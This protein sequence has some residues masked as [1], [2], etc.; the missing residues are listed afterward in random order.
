[1]VN[2]FLPLYLKDIGASGFYIALT[3]SGCALAK[4]L[5]TPLFGRWS[6]N[7]SRRLFISLGLS[8]YCSISFGCL[9]LPRSLPVWSL[10][11]IF[12]GVGAS[13]VRPLALASI[14]DI[15]PRNQEGMAMGTFD[16]S[17]YLATG[18]GP[19]LGGSMKDA[20][21][22][23]GIFGSLFGLC[24][25]ALLLSLFAVS[26]FPSAGKN[27]ETTVGFRVLSQSQGLLGLSCFIFTRSFGIVLVA[28]FL[29]VLLSHE[30]KL[31]GLQIG[32]VMAFGT[33]VTALFLRPFGEISDRVDRRV[34]IQIG[35]MSAALVTFLLPFAQGFWHMILFCGGIGFFSALTL[36]ASSA[37]LI[38]EGHRYGMG[39]TI[40]LFNAAMNL[41]FV[42]APLLGGVLMDHFT[43]PS[44]FHAAGLIGIAGMVCF[45]FLS[46]SKTC[47][48]K[49]Q[50]AQS[51]GGR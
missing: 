9:F 39:L 10:F 48:A 26:E 21:G 22:Y 17:F 47:T 6:D 12:Q 33:I 16:V 4:L 32:S 28:I 44:I 42:L 11:V 38:E 45:M 30:L 3:Y 19:I 35:G 15:A 31:N 41:G 18:V 43:L 1:M 37:L 34:L 46:K 7:G 2:P 8:V 51:N 25:F 49:T 13:L 5:L 20:L 24:L 23:S 14:A 29:P 27:S 40:G 36:P 50:V